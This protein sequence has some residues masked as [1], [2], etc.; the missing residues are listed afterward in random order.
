VPIVLFGTEH[1]KRLIHWDVLVEEGM[2]SPED[3]DLIKMVDDPQAAWEH[4]VQF[5]SLKQN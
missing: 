2:I 5:Y 1:W 4:I 3:L